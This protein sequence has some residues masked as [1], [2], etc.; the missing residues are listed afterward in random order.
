MR[1]P[2]LFA[3]LA[4]TLTACAP[5]RPPSGL[6]RALYTV[7]TN[8]VSSVLPQVLSNGTVVAITNQVPVYRLVPSAGTEAAL[9][10]VGFG[11]GS[12]FGLGGVLSAVLAGLYNLYAS[13]RNRKV[14]RALVQGTETV[15]EVLKAAPEGSTLRERAVTWLETQQ[16]AAGVVEEIAKAVRNVDTRSARAAAQEVRDGV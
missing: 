2:I 16:K 8:Y 14:T 9:Q 3:L 13:A 15:L 6:E 12:V 1:N 7:E 11:V 4:L 10:G 5:N